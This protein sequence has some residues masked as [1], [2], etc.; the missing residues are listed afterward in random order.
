M[1][2]RHPQSGQDNVTTLYYYTQVHKITWYTPR[3]PWKLGEWAQQI[4]YIHA[5]FRR[6][7]LP[8]T[9]W[10]L[11]T[12]AQRQRPTI[13]CSITLAHS[14]RLSIFHKTNELIDYISKN[15][16]DNEVQVLVLHQYWRQLRY[17]KQSFHDLNAPIQQHH[18]YPPTTQNKREVSAAVTLP[19]WPL[20]PQL[21]P[22]ERRWRRCTKSQ[23][24]R[25][26]HHPK[27]FPKKY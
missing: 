19:T 21:Q 15:K 3:I 7:P 17:T 8:N 1:L 23:H 4:F 12:R 13:L 20:T 11:I 18:S 14:R 22:G 5:C 9:I 2:N 24:T 16:K 10:L 25:K 6:P 26:T 27:K